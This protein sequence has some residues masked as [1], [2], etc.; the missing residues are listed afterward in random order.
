MHQKYY[1]T[2]FIAAAWK[3]MTGGLDIPVFQC[4][5]T[6]ADVCGGA[7]IQYMQL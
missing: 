7:P 5:Y 6:L 2:S 3:V 4:E 1:T